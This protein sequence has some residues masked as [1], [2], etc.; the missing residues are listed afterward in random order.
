[1]RNMQNPETKPCLE[2]GGDRVFVSTVV[3]GTSGL[4]GN[5]IFQQPRRSV[6]FFG[7]NKRSN[8]SSSQALVCLQ[9]GHTTFFATQTE[10]LIPD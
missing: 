10:N 6:S 1:M 9:C 5:I 4:P 8:N 2:C 7:K 3:R